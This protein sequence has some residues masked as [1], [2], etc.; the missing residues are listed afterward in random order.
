MASKCIKQGC[1]FWIVNVKSRLTSVLLAGKIHQV[2]QMSALLHHQWFQ[3]CYIRRLP[4]PGLGHCCAAEPWGVGSQR[5]RFG[6]SDPTL[7]HPPAL[8]PCRT[9][10]GHLLDLQSVLCYPHHI[11][12][13]SHLN[14]VSQYRIHWARL[15]F[16][17]HSVLHGVFLTLLF[18][19]GSPLNFWQQALLFQSSFPCHF[20]EG[21]LCDPFLSLF[22]GISVPPWLPRT[23]V[24]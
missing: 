9:T 1:S 15:A 13:M 3:S 16:F 18:I 17:G 8:L 14:I 5:L 23:A 19:T 10:L 6:S 21:A 11:E 24:T 12:L 22:Q 4:C 7:C 20:P 2:N